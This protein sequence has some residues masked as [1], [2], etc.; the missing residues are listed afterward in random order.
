MTLELPVDEFEYLRDAQKGI[1]NILGFIENYLRFALSKDPLR[2]KAC[3]TCSGSCTS[4]CDSNCEGNCKG[5]CFT[6]CRGSCA[7]ECKGS[8][9]SQCTDTSA[10]RGGS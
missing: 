5:S 2:L 3:E 6:E 10:M 9:F 1:E 7:N 8:C 4:D